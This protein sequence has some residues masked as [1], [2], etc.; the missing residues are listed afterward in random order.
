MHIEKN[1]CDSLLGTLLDIT[2][3][4]KDHHKARLDMKEMGIRKELHPLDSGD[5]RFVLLPK[6]SFSMTKEEK[7]IFCGVIKKAKLPQGCSSNLVR[8][9]QV[10][11][12]KILGYKS[13]DAHIIMHHLL[14][15]AIIKTLPKHVAL[16]LI[17]LSAFFRSICNRVINPNDLDRLQTDISETL[18]DLE[19]I[20]PPSFFD[21][22]VHLPVHLVNEVK[23]G[24]PVCDWWM[25]PIERYLGKLKS[26]VKNRN[27][28]EASIAEGYLAEECLVF[29]SRYLNDGEKMR[30]KGSN[31][32]HKTDDKATDEGSSLFPITGY[33]L[34]RKKK[35]KKGNAFSLDSKT[36]TLA[37]R[38]VL[39]NCEDEQVQYYIE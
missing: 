1:I 37:H 8:C 9:V 25:Y 32:S 29:C 2:G 31:Q 22:M 19:R 34:G 39:F 24:G 30:S 5:D 33:P 15:V 7:R 10:K 36:R 35:G 14:S 38:Y 13:H 17:R 3:K 21:I 28:P 4:S 11:E 23:L 27:R 16:P 12:G 6:A 20:F 26:Y 18:C